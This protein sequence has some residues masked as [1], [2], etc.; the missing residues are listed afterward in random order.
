MFV[1]QKNN[2][3]YVAEQPK[4]IQGAHGH[5]HLDD[6][7]NPTM[8]ARAR[9]NGGGEQTTARSP[10]TTIAGRGVS[11]TTTYSASSQLSL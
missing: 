9:F 2:T 3:K 7:V 1:G 11:V 8:P 6:R 10:A 4:E 5:T